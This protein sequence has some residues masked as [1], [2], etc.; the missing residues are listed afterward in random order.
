MKIKKFLG[1]AMLLLSAVV[2]NAGVA[3]M[4]LVGT[5]EM[6]QSMKNNR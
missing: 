5:E 6:P 2:V 4:L 1:G 3:S